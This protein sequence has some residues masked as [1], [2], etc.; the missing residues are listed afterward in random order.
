MAC[1]QAKSKFITFIFSS[2]KTEQILLLLIFIWLFQVLVVAQGI[3]S[4]GSLG[5]GMRILFCGMWDL[6]PWPAMEPRPPALGAWSLSHWTTR[7]VPK[8]EQILEVVYL[9]AA[10]FCFRLHSCIHLM[11]LPVQEQTQFHL[12]IWKLE[13]W[14]SQGLKG[15]G[16][17][18][19]GTTSYPQEDHED[20]MSE[21][22]ERSN[23]PCPVTHEICNSCYY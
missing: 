22:L 16:S 18:G 15:L 19:S 1:G 2:L 20:E 21:P 17:R 23:V 8:I 13:V 11:A 12:I 14:C 7:E 4:L 3:F 5:T 9:T 6:D 10:I